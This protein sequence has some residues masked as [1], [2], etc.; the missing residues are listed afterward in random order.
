MHDARPHFTADA[1]EV[2]DVVQQRVDQ[3][4]GR[5]A[6][7][8]MH[9]HAGGLVDD[10]DIGVVEENFERQ[11]FRQRR[12]GLRL[13]QLDADHIA[14]ANVGVRLDL[15]VARVADMAVLDQPLDL[16][17]RQIR[18]L[19]GQVAIEALT[20]VFRLRGELEPIH[21]KRGLRGP[22]AASGSTGR[23][24]RLKYH[25]MK[26]LSGASTTEMNCEVDNRPSTR[27]RSSPR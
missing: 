9:H 4:A 16:R 10:D 12:R 20:D 2:L 18:D 1:A 5:V 26:M 11:I 22:R 23:A 21:A 24:G 3:R 27:P 6:G 13:R 7:G 15:L 8:G 14:F 19:R 17:T 25:N